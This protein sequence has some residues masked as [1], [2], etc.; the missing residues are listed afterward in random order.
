V[1]IGLG[2]L[3]GLGLLFLWLKGH[4]FGAIIPALAI[5]W[6][7][8]MATGAPSDPAFYIAGRG[9][10]SLFV[11]FLPHLLWGRAGVY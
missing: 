6:L 1:G 2:G 4:W 8:Q 5:F 11:A 10:I 3:V 9:L 7:F